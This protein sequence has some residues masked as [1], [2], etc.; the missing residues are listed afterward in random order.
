M[1]LC[2]LALVALLASLPAVGGGGMG[3]ALEAFVDAAIPADAAIHEKC[4][5][6]CGVG[7]VATPRLPV[8]DHRPTANGWSVHAPHRQH[9]AAPRGCRGTHTAAPAAATACWCTSGPQS[10]NS[11][12]AGDGRYQVKEPY[13][14]VELSHWSPL[15]ICC[16]LR[17]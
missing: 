12:Q 16:A 4:T 17:L 6:P 11:T 10:G 5:Q 7:R 2:P 8:R 13:G 15:S 14:L 3:A 1:H 9:N